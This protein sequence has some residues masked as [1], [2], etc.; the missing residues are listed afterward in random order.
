MPKLS[1][2]ASFYREECSKAL[3]LNE[4]QELLMSENGFMTGVMHARN[5]CNLDEIIAVTD[6]PQ[7]PSS[8]A[9]LLSVTVDVQTQLALLYG[10]YTCLESGLPRSQAVDGESSRSREFPRDKSILL[11][12]CDHR[13]ETEYDTSGGGERLSGNNSFPQAKPLSKSWLAF[14]Q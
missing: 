13:P 9:D 3:K 14:W 6:P 11:T 10:F 8:S 5:L 7:Q 12:H 4:V 1:H 2:I